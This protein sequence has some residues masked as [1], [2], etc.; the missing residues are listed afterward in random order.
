MNEYHKIH[1]VF[2]RD[3]K[4]KCRTLLE[5][6]YSLPEFEYLSHNQWTWTEKVDGTNIR[7]MFRGGEV[8]F[9]GKA[10]RAQIPAPL[11]NRLNAQFDRERLIAAFDGD[12]CLY[13]EGYGAGIQKGGSNYRP[14][15]GFVL[16]DVRVGDGWLQRHDVV[17]VAR[18]LDV[19]IV[20][21]VGGG[22]LPSRVEK[23]RDG[24][25]SF[26]GGFPA[27]GIVARPATELCT[28]DGDR[29]ITKLKFK[30]FSV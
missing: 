13:G 24:T 26:W 20:P 15:Q 30:D 12:A 17:D 19:E 23:V 3:P 28:R 27:E 2:E 8:S 4:N 14:T 29:I 18:K 1:T 6:Q 21:V 16:F 11:V 7:V 10:E 25:N 5:G 22:T 9:G